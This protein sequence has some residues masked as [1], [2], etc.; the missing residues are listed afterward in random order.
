MTENGDPY[1]HILAEQMNR[2]MKEEFGLGE[3]YYLC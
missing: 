2:T 1:E 3:R